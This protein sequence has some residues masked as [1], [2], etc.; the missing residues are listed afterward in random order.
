[1]GQNGAVVGQVP[2]FGPFP[3]EKISKRGTKKGGKPSSTKSSFQ[4]P[5]RFLI[6]KEVL[7]SHFEV[8]EAL[9]LAWWLN[10]LI[11]SANK[12]SAQTTGG[13]RLPA[14]FMKHQI[15]LFEH[16]LHRKRNISRHLLS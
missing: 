10:T 7:L 13:I 6:L 11:F 8:K 12:Y 9:D 3:L 1:M 16:D 15:M 14:N 5:K 2:H 4:H